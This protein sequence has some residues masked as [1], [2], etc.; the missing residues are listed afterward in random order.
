M[1]PEERIFPDRRRLFATLAADVQTRL[2]EAIAKRRKASMALAGGSTPGPLYEALSVAPLK[3]DKVHLTLTDERWIAPQD[4]AS[5][6]FLVRDL[7]LKRRA[8]EAQFVP[9]KTNHAKPAGA[10]AT[11]ERRVAALLPFDICLLGMGADGHIASLIPGADG[12]AHAADP[13]SEKRISAVH[14]H[15]AAGAAERLTLSLSGIL[16]SRRII[17]LFM[18][19]DKM[20]VFRA[21]VAGELESPVRTVWAQH[22]TPVQAY[23]AP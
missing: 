9:F 14:A 4:P 23:W 12:Y 10:A 22:K 18:G 19:A 1:T 17:L 8:A 6:E 13:H 3:W 5:N 16:A 20:S 11:T 15:G 7:L 2:S 21:A